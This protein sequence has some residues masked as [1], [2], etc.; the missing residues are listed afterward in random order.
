MIGLAVAIGIFGRPAASED[1]LTKSPNTN[2]QVREGEYKSFTTID[3]LK[4]AFKFYTDPKT[5]KDSAVI[6]TYDTQPMQSD[7]TQRLY[8]MAKQD[9][10]GIATRKEN[11]SYLVLPGNKFLETLRYSQG[12]QSCADS[13]LRQNWKQHL[14]KKPD[15][16]VSPHDKLLGEEYNGTIFTRQANPMRM[17]GS[18]QES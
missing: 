1:D 16:V 4:L 15:S 13:C 14:E 9:Q 18:G 11:G 10:I 6:Y 12:E 7:V 5:A 17:L 8:E 2:E 3:R